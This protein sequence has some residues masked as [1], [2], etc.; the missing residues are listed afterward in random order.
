MYVCVCGFFFREEKRAAWSEARRYRE[1]ERAEDEDRSVSAQTPQASYSQ[2]SESRTTKTER[3]QK[4]GK[5]ILDERREN[6]EDDSCVLPLSLSPSLAATHSTDS[7]LPKKETQR[8]DMEDQTV[9]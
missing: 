9:D 4:E 6:V 3:N 7:S 8:L 5:E 2:A 1:G